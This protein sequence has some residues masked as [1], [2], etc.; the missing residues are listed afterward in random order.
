[1]NIEEI[2][3]ILT[4]DDIENLLSYLDAEPKRQNNIIICRT[5]CHAGHSHKLYYY[6][7]TKL[8]K[9]YT[10]CAGDSFDIGEL[11]IKVKETE[12]V[13]IT[14]PQ[15]VLFLKNFFNLAENKE[16]SFF[17][18]IDESEDWKILN[19]YSENNKK[20]TNNQIVE[21][22]YYDDKILTFLPHPRILPW[23]QERNYQIINRTS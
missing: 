21:F 2:K 18:K 8:F 12:G 3:N 23:E 14:L 7:N 10:D 13:N 4:L 16:E 19:Y 17:G 22:K 1:M 15:S 20:E 9:C 5:I 11:I 6:D